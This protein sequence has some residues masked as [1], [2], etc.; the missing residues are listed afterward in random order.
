[1]NV[2]PFIS[3]GISA[4]LLVALLCHSVFALEP[5]IE[6]YGKDKNGARHVNATEAAE[7]LK[8]YPTVQVLDVRTEKEYKRGHISDSINIDYHGSQFKKQLDKLDRNT[9]WLVHCHSGVRSGRSLGILKSLGFKSIIHLDG[10][11][12]AWTE[13][14]QPLQKN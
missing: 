11:A 8:K 6:T 9:T 10:G 1:M 12:L 3:A 5:G 4:V 7:I 13:A 14:K 2:R